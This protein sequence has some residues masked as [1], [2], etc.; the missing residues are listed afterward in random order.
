MGARRHHRYVEVLCDEKRDPT[1]QDFENTDPEQLMLLEKAFYSHRAACPAR[2]YSILRATIARFPAYPP[3]IGR[4]ISMSITE[5]TVDL[6]SIR[7]R[8]DRLGVRL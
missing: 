5:K 2:L 4:T 1:K 6:E 8:L 7:Q 3:S